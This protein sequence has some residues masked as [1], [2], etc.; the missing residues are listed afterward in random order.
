LLLK[1]AAEMMVVVKRREL[2]AKA[3]GKQK[4]Q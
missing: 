4:V 2:S 1:E 3:K